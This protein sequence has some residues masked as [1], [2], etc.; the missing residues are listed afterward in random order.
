MATV[1]N[2]IFFTAKWV[3]FYVKLLAYK[4]PHPFAA[5]SCVCGR[6]TIRAAGGGS[7]YVGSEDGSGEKLCGAV[8]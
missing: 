3:T 7:S 5:L 1:L 4:T 6:G 8:V 2:F